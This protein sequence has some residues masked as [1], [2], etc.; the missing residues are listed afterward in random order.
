LIATKPTGFHLGREMDQ[1]WH[2]YFSRKNVI[3]DRGAILATTREKMQ[4]LGI[5]ITSRTTPRSCSR[6]TSRRIEAFAL[7]EELFGE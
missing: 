1:A 3:G 5:A 6:A 4:T 2:K 7:T